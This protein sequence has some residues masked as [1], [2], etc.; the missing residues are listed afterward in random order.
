MVRVSHDVNIHVFIWCTLNLNV[1]DSATTILGK[2]LGGRN[3]SEN[4]QSMADSKCFSQAESRLQC[5][6]ANVYLSS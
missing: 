3:I 2:T 6:A 4:V 5:C 1:N